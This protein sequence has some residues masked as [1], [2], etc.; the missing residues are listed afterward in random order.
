MPQ[1]EFQARIELVL[2]L[3]SSIALGGCGARSSGTRLARSGGAEALDVALAGD[4][5]GVVVYQRR[6]GKDATTAMELWLAEFAPDSGFLP[7][8][9]LLAATDGVAPRAV[10]APDG[11]LHV[12]WLSAALETSF[13]G[14][15]VMVQRRRTGVSGFEPSVELDSEFVYPQH[16]RLAGSRAGDAIVV[17]AHAGGIFASVSTGDTDFVAPERLA[18]V[19]DPFLGF[20]CAVAMN[21]AGVALIVHSVGV[22]ADESQVAAH[23][24]EPGIGFTSLGVVATGPTIR[25]LATALAEDGACV[26]AWTDQPLALGDE[27]T[28]PTLRVRLGAVDA[29]SATWPPSETLAMASPGE[30]SPLEPAAGFDDS[31]TAFIAWSAGAT[32][33]LQIC[34]APPGGSFGAPDGTAVPSWGGQEGF[35]FSVDPAGRATLLAERPDRGVDLPP[36]V[37]ACR[38]DVVAAA[39]PAIELVSARRGDRFTGITDLDADREL[40][41]GA[42]I[43]NG[44]VETFVWRVPLAG[45]AVDPIVPEAGV[46]ARFSATSVA[47]T[48]SA[49]IALDEWDFDSDGAYE[50]TGSSVLHTFA[51][52]GSYSVTTRATDEWGDVA[53]ASQIVT[54][55]GGGGGPPWLLQVVLDGNGR[56][57]GDRDSNGDRLLDIDC[58]A[59]CS[60]VYAGGLITFLTPTADSGHHFV[61]W[62]GLSP[63]FDQDF[64]VE[65]CEVVMNQDKTITAVFAVD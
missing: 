49:R 52:A 13:L 39:S 1:R 16:L 58:P 64:G 47:R 27:V 14:G 61:R 19:V 51:T 21:G 43:E 50:A 56:V 53:T 8:E 54:V 36:D 62:E 2:L 5:R 41:L 10:I 24:F 29:T 45:F 38:Y 30:L 17:W 63:T 9:P 60:E 44:F 48:D 4:G 42:W 31:G 40:T 12:A 57:Q 59:D 23:R 6:T 46:A 7:E 34:R 25:S 28:E 65:G 11:T 3:L 20:E 33:L 35:S 37:L 26:V 55:G 32:E 22:A 18:D 15:S